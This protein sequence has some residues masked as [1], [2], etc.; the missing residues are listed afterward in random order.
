LASVLTLWTMDGLCCL[1]MLISFDQHRVFGRRVT[2][3][4]LFTMAHM[5]KT[6][7]CFA[8][9]NST[10]LTHPVPHL[11]QHLCEFTCTCY[12]KPTCRC[13]MLKQG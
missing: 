9:L 8:M 5:A 10:F 13:G 1:V 2:P 6:Q 11:R 7:P 12:A 3:A 4:A